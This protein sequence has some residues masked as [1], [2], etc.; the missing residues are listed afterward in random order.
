MAADY[1]IVDPTSVAETAF[2]E[3]GV[4]HRKLTEELG[5]RDMRV[6]QVTVDPGEV[7]GYHSHNRQEEIYV[8]HKG[9]GE[10]YLD[11]D[12]RE[13]PEGGIVRISADVPRQLLNTGSKPSVWIMFGAPP[14]GTLEDYGE[15]QVEEGGFRAEE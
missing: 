10:V 8:C 2:P 1:R 14:I 9:P 12:H 15:Y 3:S 7:V 11:G 13:V 4:S 5:A 6:N